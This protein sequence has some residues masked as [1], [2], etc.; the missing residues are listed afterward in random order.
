MVK[1]IHPI[2][3]PCTHPLNMTIYYIQTG[4]LAGVYPDNKVNAA[5]A[6]EILD[7]CEDIFGLLSAA[8]KGKEKDEEKKAAAD[9]LVAEGGKLRY[10]VDK[11]ANRQKEAADRGVKSGLFICEELTIAELKF[12]ATLGFVMGRLP[13]F[14][15]DGLMGEDKYKPLL[16]IIDTVNGNDKVKALEEQLQKNFAAFKEK[17]ENNTFKYAGKT[18]SGSL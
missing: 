3:Y 12:A 4:K 14:G 8:M 16:N 18:V 15:K 11:F 7:S 2:Q 10:W 1:Y 9:E 13:G 17:S 6:D 5:L